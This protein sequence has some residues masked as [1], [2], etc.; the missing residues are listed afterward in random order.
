[1]GQRILSQGRRRA[2]H[3]HRRGSDNGSGI[4]RMA[5]RY[6]S[7]IF[8][9]TLPHYES[10]LT[11]IPVVILD[12]GKYAPKFT[13]GF[14]VMCGFS[15]CEFGIIFVL[16]YFAKREAELDRRE[17][18]KRL[19]GDAAPDAIASSHSRDAEERDTPVGDIPPRLSLKDFDQEVLE[20]K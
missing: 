13:L 3:R 10:I 5:A 2:R 16:R 17:E 11:I 1:M 18:E 15:A 6:V 12:V 4:Y 7:S 19:T 9:F 20:V 8:V 14:S